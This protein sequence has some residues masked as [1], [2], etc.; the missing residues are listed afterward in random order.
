MKDEIQTIVCSIG[1]VGFNIKYSQ[2]LIS[3]KINVYISIQNELPNGL[4]PRQIAFDFYYT[5]E[6]YLVKQVMDHS[7]EQMGIS[8]R[9]KIIDYGYYADYITTFN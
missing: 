9:K 2:S 4:G 1:G 7:K 3:D 6:L 5:S 8:K